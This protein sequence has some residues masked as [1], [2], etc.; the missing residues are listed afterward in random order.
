MPF[1]CG[2]HYISVCLVSGKKSVDPAIAFSDPQFKLDTYCIFSSVGWG[3]A[4][5]DTS[6]SKHKSASLVELRQLK[7]TG[8]TDFWQRMEPAALE[9]LGQRMFSAPFL[10]IESYLEQISHGHQRHRIFWGSSLAIG[11]KHMQSGV[12]SC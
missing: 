8:G 6:P 4:N 2:G 5:Q 10:V 12:F 3:G 9:A 1:A 11:D 7:E